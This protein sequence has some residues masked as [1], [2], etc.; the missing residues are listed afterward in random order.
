MKYALL[1]ITNL[2]EEN[3]IKYLCMVGGNF[4]CEWFMRLINKLE[5]R[6]YKIIIW[7]PFDYI[8]TFDCLENISKADII[9]TTNPIMSQEI[10]KIIQKVYIEKIDMYNFIIDWIHHGVSNSFKKIENKKSLIEDINNLNFYYN[11]KKITENDIII[12]NANNFVKRKNLNDTLIV[13]K[14]LQNKLK[15]KNIRLWIHTNTQDP[16][17]EKFYN[18]A[19]KWIKGLIITHNDVSSEILNNIYN[20]CK[21]GLQTSSGE[22]WSLTN[23]EHEITGAIQIVPKFLATEFNFKDTGKLI[24]VELINS[25]DE[26]ENNIIISKINT[27]NACN[28]LIDI[29]KNNLFNPYIPNNENSKEI[30]YTWESAASKLIS[31]LN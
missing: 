27:N 17:F 15:N 2:I 21:I 22:G 6:N 14:K 30:L 7:T 18:N 3:N 29:I 19:K 23:C 8:P 1:Q 28:I 9:L 16:E 5:M 13:I 10:N 11:S 4:V 26:N 31:Y 25:Q 24:D 12:L 20:V